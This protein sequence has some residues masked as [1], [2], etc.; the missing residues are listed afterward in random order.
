MPVFCFD[1][2]LLDGR[3]ASGPRTQFLLE[4]LADLDGELRQRRSGLV[5]R[6][7]RPE[8]ELARLAEEV[9]AEAIHDTEDVSPFAHK[10]AERMRRAGLS[11]TS[12]PG[13]NAIDVSTIETKAGKPYSVF[14]PFHRA[15]LETQRRD[16]LTAPQR[17]PPLPADLAKGRVPPLD[18][19]GLTQE[20]DDPAPGGE[21]A[22]RKALK[23]FLDGP[24][25]DY[26]SDHDALG[27]DNTSRLS[28]YLHF[29]CLSARAI[30]ERLPQRRGAGGLPSPA[31]RGATSTT[32]SC[33]T[34]RA[35]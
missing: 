25:R 4:C 13:L 34:S 17:L 33:T 30:E 18:S 7:G 14:S 5:I 28:P 2:R 20:V 29:G 21:A 1:D 6:R 27:R 19:L 12:H 35:M 15:W 24:I 16:V 31:S 32:T 23:R 9:G 26:A 3:H 10:R 22:A 11:L 8:H